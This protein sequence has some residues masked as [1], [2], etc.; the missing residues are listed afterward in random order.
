VVAAAAGLI[1]VILRPGG[2]LRRPA[3]LGMLITLRSWAPR[4]L[5]AGLLHLAFF[6]VG[7]LILWTVAEP[8]RAR[9]A[10]QLEL[11]GAISALAVGW[12]AGFVVPGA[13]AGLGVREAVL[14][15]TLEPHLG[16]DGAVLAALAL[17]VVTALGDLLF[18]GLSCLTPAHRGRKASAIRS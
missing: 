3:T 7:G 1:L 11:L 12:W 15:L 8:V 6:A 2:A 4:L 10:P 17:R 5:R 9:G 16:G 14:V 18:F 13:A